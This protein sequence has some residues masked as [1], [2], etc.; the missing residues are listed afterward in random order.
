MVES[1]TE[2]KETNNNN[3]IVKK[4]C[5]FKVCNLN[6]DFICGGVTALLFSA[7]YWLIRCRGRTD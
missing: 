1:N 7:G 6:K 4:E 2:I 3:I 5:P